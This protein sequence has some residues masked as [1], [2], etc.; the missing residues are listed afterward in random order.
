MLRLAHSLFVEETTCVNV[1][2]FLRAVSS[3]CDEKREEKGERE[4]DSRRTSYCETLNNRFNVFCGD[5]LLLYVGIS[6]RVERVRSFFFFFKRDKSLF[7]ENENDNLCGEF[8]SKFFSL[9]WRII[10][11]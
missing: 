3:A 4:V 10:D 6:G 5:L 9:T 2:R 11:D 1:C 8:L 7:N